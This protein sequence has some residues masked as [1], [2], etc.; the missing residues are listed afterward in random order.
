MSRESMRSFVK[1]SFCV[2]GVEKH[3]ALEKEWLRMTEETKPIVELLE[4]DEVT[5]R[6][7]SDKPELVLDYLRKEH[8]VR[9]SSD[10]ICLFPSW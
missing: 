7:K 5:N 3:E 9:W 6:L 4:S 8:K 2:T 1:S 10:G